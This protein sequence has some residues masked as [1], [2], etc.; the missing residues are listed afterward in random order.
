MTKEMEEMRN[1]ISM[2]EMRKNAYTKETLLDVIGSYLCMI[3]R[4]GKEYPTV[5][6]H[7][8]E[9]SMKY[10]LKVNEYDGKY[11]DYL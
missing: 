2:Q 8:L 9:S 6:L 7:D 1:D 5:T 11:K 10:V 3:N 4:N